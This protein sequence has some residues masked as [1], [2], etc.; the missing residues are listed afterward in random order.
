M[1]I[2]RCFSPTRRT[3]FTV[4]PPSDVNVAWFGSLAAKVPLAALMASGWSIL[5]KPTG[6]HHE[7]STSIP[8]PSP[9]WPRLYVIGWPES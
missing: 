4:N 7:P 8:L 9:Q 3:R 6:S 5:T 2:G 1:H